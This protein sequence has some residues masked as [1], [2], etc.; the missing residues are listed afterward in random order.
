M[1]A[2]RLIDLTCHVV[3]TATRFPFRYGIA[4]MTAAPH[5]FLRAEFEVGG[6]RVTGFSAEGLPPKWFVKSPDTTFDDDLPDM[7]EAIRNAVDA[8][9]GIGEHPGFFDW[10]L[11]L[12]RQQESWA[13][14]RGTPPLLAHLGTSLVE[15]AGIDALCRAA[16][17]PFA[18]VLAGGG[19]DLRLGEIHPELGTIPAASLL[20]REGAVPDSTLL[21]RH[22]VG[23]ADP[24]TD[25]EIREEDRVEDGL[26]HSLEACVRAYGIRYFKIKLSGLADHD[27]E[28]LKRLAGILERL[29]PDYRYTLDGNEQFRDFG[30]FWA[31]WEQLQADPGLASFLSPEHLLF[32]EQPLHREVALADGVEGILACWEDAPPFIIDESDANLDSARRALDL[33]YSGTSHKNCKGVIKGIANACLLARRSRT[34]AGGPCILSGEDLANIGPVALL[35]DLAVMHALGIAHVERNGHHY[36][37]GLGMMPRPVQAAVLAKHGDLYRDHA[38]Y[39]S[40]AIRDGRVDIGSVV[41]APFGTAFGMDEVI[42]DWCSLDTWESEGAFRGY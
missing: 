35:Q 24:L 27:C 16:G 32:V 15:R 12:Y 34:G 5:L 36:F 18:A 40:L 33:G 23:L 8:A 4:A 25:D 14:G 9:V 30:D 3:R 31:L 21:I 6:E 19:L 17:R 7:V 26:P 11:A 10:W 38:G 13:A 2:I 29:V 39:P 1:P 28:R 22:T 41:A 37:A 42:D 20:T